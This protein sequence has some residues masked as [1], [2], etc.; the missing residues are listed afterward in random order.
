MH[1]LQFVLRPHP[2]PDLLQSTSMHYRMLYNDH[3][4]LRQTLAYS[5]NICHVTD[6]LSVLI[7]VV[8]AIF[9]LIVHP[10]Y[11]FLIWN[12]YSTLNNAA[13]RNQST[14][15]NVAGLIF[16]CILVWKPR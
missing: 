15:V 13:I 4:L 7:A 12:N 14:D 8:P 3:Q 1:H 2:A 5:F 9:E 6:E 10:I 11:D 16:D